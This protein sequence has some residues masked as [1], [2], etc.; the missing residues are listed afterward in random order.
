MKTRRS[1]WMVVVVFL[2]VSF[3]LPAV[4]AAAQSAVR[5]PVVVYEYL[6][7][8]EE[9][10]VTFP[11]GNYHERGAMHATTE[12]SVNSCLNGPGFIEYKI[13]AN[14][15]GHVYAGGT[16]VIEVEDYDGSWEMVWH[17]TTKMPIT[18]IGQ[19]TGEFE[20]IQIKL[21]ETAFDE[22]ENSDADLKFVGELLVPPHAQGQCV[23]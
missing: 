20:G 16:W 2:L 19:G 3:L 14:K 22:E 12:M 23:E 5:V 18:A 6:D 15:N 4:G 13:N 17:V 8:H 10:E 7:S 1:L 21:T 9:G 11:G